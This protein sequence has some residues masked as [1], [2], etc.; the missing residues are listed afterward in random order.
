M[1]QK[2]T[3]LLSLRSTLIP[4]EH[5]RWNS[6][7]IK[8]GISQVRCG[9]RP[10]VGNRGSV[11]LSSLTDTQPHSHSLLFIKLPPSP[12]KLCA[13]LQKPLQA[14]RVSVFVGGAAKNNLVLIFPQIC[15]SEEWSPAPSALAQ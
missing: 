5:V 4:V 10:T 13:S 2:L 8:T 6:P 1:C 9:N 3:D 14:H 15:R 12:S 11:P 7:P